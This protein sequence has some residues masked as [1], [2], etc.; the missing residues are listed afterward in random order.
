MACL[1]VSNAATSF[2]DH[3]RYPTAPIKT[4]FGGF[5]LPAAIHFCKVTWWI[6]PRLAA[7]AVVSLLPII[8]C[9]YSVFQVD[10]HE[11]IFVL[12]IRQYF[13][14]NHGTGK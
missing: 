11:L 4:G 6:P 12:G 5:T 10:C 7:S 13:H 2:A 1:T 9:M 14:V 3:S 8:G